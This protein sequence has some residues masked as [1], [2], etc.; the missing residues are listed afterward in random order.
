[1]AE[2]KIIGAVIGF[3]VILYVLYF[4]SLKPPCRDFNQGG[5]SINETVSITA[6]FA[7][8]SAEQAKGLSGCAALELGQG[9]YFPFAEK[10]EAVF[11][12]KDM[13]MSIDII[14]ITDSRVVGIE[15][16]VPPP[17]DNNL[18]KYYA[19]GE[20]DAVLEIGAG[21]AAELGITKGASVRVLYY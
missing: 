18:I 12:M 15:H 8:T 5:I 1:M 4:F 16:S 17:S 7:I 6:N 2:K 19:P 3:G 20:V 10:K 14:W 13:I 21:H 11:W 9:M